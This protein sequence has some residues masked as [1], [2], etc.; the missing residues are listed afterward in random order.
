VRGALAWIVTLIASCAPDYGHTAFLCDTGHDCPTGQMCTFGRC[1]R[2]TPPDAQSVACGDA[3]CNVGTQQCCVDS[4]GGTRGMQCGSASEVCPGT[5]ALCDGPA[6][7]QHGDQCC[8][9]GS[10]VFCDKACDQYACQVDS[11]C[12]LTA[13]HCCH[14][15]MTPWGMCSEL[16]C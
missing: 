6:D 11:D 8:A 4:A 15:P 5:S 9:D 16:D 14:D 2:G 1:W 12:P 13:P 3:G 10:T 7:C